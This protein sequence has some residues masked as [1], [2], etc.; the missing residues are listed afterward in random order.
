[1]VIKKNKKQRIP[2]DKVI[3]NLS[4]KK[5]QIPKFTQKANM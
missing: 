3:V 4:N 1:M 2:L 5:F